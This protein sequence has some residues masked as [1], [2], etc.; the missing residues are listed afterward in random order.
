[1]RVLD[2]NFLIDYLDGDPDTEAYYR[3]VPRKNSG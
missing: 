1:M 3:A 2:A